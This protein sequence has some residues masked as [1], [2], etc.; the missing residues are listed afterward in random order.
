MQRTLCDTRELQKFVEWQYRMESDATP[1]E[2][3]SRT[4]WSQQPH[5]VESN[6]PTSGVS[7]RT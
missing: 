6:T 1:S 2:G 5:R 7:S 3:S 4:E